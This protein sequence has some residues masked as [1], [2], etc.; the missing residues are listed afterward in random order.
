MN[1]AQS[2]TPEEVRAWLRLLM[3]PGAG[4]ATQ[5]QLLQIW[6]WPTAIFDTSLAEKR[7]QVS[8]SLAMA[9]HQTPPELEATWDRTMAWLEREQCHLI[10]LGAASYPAALLQTADPPVCLFAQGHLDGWH[11]RQ[12]LAMVGSRNPTPQGVANARAFARE[13]AEQGLGVVSGLALGIDGAAHEGALAG[14]GPTIAVVGTGLDRVYPKGHHALAH[15]IAETGLLLSEYVLGSPPLAAHF[16]QR[17]RIIS[18]LSA[19]VLVVEATL[20]SGSLITA[21]LAGDQ[22]REVFAIP[23]SIHSPQSKGCHAL[24]RQGAKLVESAQDVIEEL[25]WANPMAARTQKSGEITRRAA[26]D[27]ETAPAKSGQPPA[28]E[29][30]RPSVASMLTAMGQEV[31]DID[32]LMQRTQTSAA[33][34]QAIL[35]ELEIMGQV[36]RLPGA[37]WQRL[38]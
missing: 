22:G 6:G 20:Q 9:L 8:E 32:V 1:S 38:N 14:R 19:G 30:L 12:W 13:F 37:R 36:A 23:G 35:M 25:G 5:R 31:T 28:A 2:H 27:P 17:N 16:P 18:G 34:A 26:L 10:T 4:P 3:T 7:A 11:D 33:D 21:R 15:Q 29:P 24:I